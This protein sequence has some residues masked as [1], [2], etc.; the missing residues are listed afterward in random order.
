MNPLP[1]PSSLAMPS[2]KKKKSHQVGRPQQIKE[3]SGI[4]IKQH[5][6]ICG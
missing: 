6:L 3:V 5:A 2:K 4:E 1:F